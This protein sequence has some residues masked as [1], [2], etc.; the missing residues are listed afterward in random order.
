MPKKSAGILAF[1]R[2]PRGIEVFLVHPGG[3]FWARKDQHAWSIPK[4]EFSDEPPLEAARREFQEE[5]GQTITGDFVTLPPMRLGGKEIHAF[6]VE[7]ED[8]DPSRI[9]SNTFEIQWPP[10]SGRLQQYPEVDRAGW[11]GLEEALLKIHKGQQALLHQFAAR[12]AQR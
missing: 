5:T 7:S 3:P 1:R 8:P 12:V 2:R 6:A 4:G 10:G 9:R 11:F